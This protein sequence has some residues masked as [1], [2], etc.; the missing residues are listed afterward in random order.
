[1]VMILAL[2]GIAVAQEVIR[3]PLTIE[4]DEEGETPAA[5]TPVETAPDPFALLPAEDQSEIQPDT[6]LSEED[7]LDLFL[8]PLDAPAG[9]AAPLEAESE[10]EESEFG[11]GEVPAE[12]LP[13]TL[14][15]ADPEAIPQDGPA[16]V[17]TLR[18]LDK[19]TARVTDIEVPVGEPVMFNSFE[20]VVQTC[21]KRP[22]EETPEVTAFTQVTE[23]RLD[24]TL[25]RI[26]SGWMYA[27]TPSL[28]P[29]EHSTYDVWLIDCRIL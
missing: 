17:A 26:F 27:S 18:G 15:Q 3:V 5:E 23:H 9:E 7:L 24:G 12:T 25:E 28:N 10:A 2:G 11:E 13:Q 8:R 22:P 29:V 14:P 4:E 19:V 21:D 20:I 6:E 1:M 16:R